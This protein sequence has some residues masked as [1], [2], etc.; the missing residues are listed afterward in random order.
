[1]PVDPETRTESKHKWEVGK[2][3][4]KKNCGGRE[5]KG[6]GWAARHRHR[7]ED[8]GAPKNLSSSDGTSA[9]RIRL[10]FSAGGWGNSRRVAYET[11]HQP[12]QKKTSWV[13]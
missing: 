13:W 9:S 2:S 3:E 5:R 11:A 1:M 12:C 6:G 4:E 7:G 8:F 10:E